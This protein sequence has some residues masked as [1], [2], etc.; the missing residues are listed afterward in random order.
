MGEEAD[1]IIED[2]LA[3]MGE[4]FYGDPPIY[5]AA[6]HKEGLRMEDGNVVQFMRPGTERDELAVLLYGKPGVGKTVLAATAPRPVFI[7]TEGGLVSITGSDAVAVRVRTSRELSQACA[8]IMQHADNFDT[9]VVDS[10]TEVQTMFMNEKL[11]AADTLSADL[12][13][14]Q[15]NTAQMRKFLRVLLSLD[16]YLIIICGE[17]FVADETGMERSSP[18]LTPKVRTETQGLMDIFC[19]LTSKA[20]GERVLFAHPRPNFLAKDRTNVISE[21][22][23]ED[24]DFSDI[25]A[26]W[27]ARRQGL[28]DEEPALSFQPAGE[29]VV[30]EDENQTQM[31]DGKE[32]ITLED[33]D[34]V[35]VKRFVKRKSEGSASGMRS[36]TEPESEDDDDDE[37]WVDPEPEE[38]PPPTPPKTK[39]KTTKTKSKATKP[40][41]TRKKTETTKTKTK[42]KSSKPKEEKRSK[43]DIQDLASRLAAGTKKKGG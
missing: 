21:D 18:A 6:Y 19:R 40:K 1:R 24:A 23:I 10:Y 5:I 11:E 34:R 41:T 13:D 32:P 3:N 4:D 39:V 26:A 2:G 12:Q 16:K 7:D 8:L 29:E 38:I 9:I 36:S 28:I 14:W 17:N 43:Q 25:F 22:G 15:V 30:E 20:K 42:K 27:E 35:K 37:E 31:F 33:G